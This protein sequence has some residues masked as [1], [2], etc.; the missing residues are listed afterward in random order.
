MGL[1]LDNNKNTLVTTSKSNM[2]FYYTLPTETNDV[3][4]Q[5]KSGLYNPSFQDC[6][7]YGIQGTLMYLFVPDNNLN[8]W[9]NY[10]KNTN[11]FNPVLKDESLRLVGDPNNE[12]TPQDPVYGLTPPQK[13]CVI[14]GDNGMSTEKSN[15]NGNPVNNTCK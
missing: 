1:S 3:K 13:Y 5:A 12:I 14:P 2:S 4:T 11:N 7:Q 15:I 6:A 10:F 8:K 9:Y